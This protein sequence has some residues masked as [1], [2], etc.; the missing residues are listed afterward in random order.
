MSALDEAEAS[1]AP[2]DL[3]ELPRQEVAA[4]LTVELVRLGEEER[5]AREVDP[6]AEDVGSDADV[7]SAREEALDL[8]APG[9]E[10]HGPVE[11]RDAPRVQPVHLAGEREHGPATERDDDR[12]R[13]S[14]SGACARRRTRAGACARR[15]SARARGTL[16]RRAGARRAPRA[17]GSRGT[18][19]RGAAA[20]RRSRARCRPPT[21]PRRA[22]AARPPGGPSRPSSRRPAR[23]RWCAPHP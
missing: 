22:R 10:R 12:A 21:A 2:G 7:G 17:A 4:L 23:A 19:R 1:G 6:V 9:G 5:L 18:R 15:P 20:S 11:D 8:L 16:D 3:R 13:A 14:A